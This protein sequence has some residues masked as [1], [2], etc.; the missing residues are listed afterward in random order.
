MREII[1]G[2]LSLG[3]IYMGEL[4]QMTVIQAKIILG[5]NY[6]GAVIWGTVVLFPFNLSVEKPKPLFCL[7][8][9]GTTKQIMKFYDCA[10]VNIDFY[11]KI[12][13]KT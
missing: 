9:T 6:P 8:Y 11:V 1:R 3:G 4:S 2:K 10:P 7:K 13:L 12:F 5:G